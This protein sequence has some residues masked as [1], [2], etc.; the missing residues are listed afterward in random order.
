MQI[1][2]VFPSP[3]TPL[4]SASLKYKILISTARDFHPWL[5]GKLI[6]LQCRQ[7]RPN[8]VAFSRA[9]ISRTV[10]PE[11]FAKKIVCSSIPCRTTSNVAAVATCCRHVYPGLAPFPREKRIF[12]I[13]RSQVCEMDNFDALG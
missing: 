3:P 7:Q 8:P 2:L 5:S 12:V 11:V 6:K 1:G 10:S 9:K 4:Q 13:K